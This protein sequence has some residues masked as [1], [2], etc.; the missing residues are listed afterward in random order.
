MISQSIHNSWHPNF[1]L[2]IWFCY[3]ETFPIILTI[4]SRY[5]GERRQHRDTTVSSS[6]HHTI[7]KAAQS[8]TPTF[9]RQRRSLI[10][11]L[12]LQPQSF[13]HTQDLRE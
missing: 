2:L 5:I 11:R 9:P 10:E 4:M 1:V 8:V 12:G 7:P 3:R 13:G 6:P